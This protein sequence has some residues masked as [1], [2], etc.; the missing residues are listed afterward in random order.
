M[1]IAFPA[2]NHDALRVPPQPCGR[3]MV[4]VRRRKEMQ[5]LSRQLFSDLN[6]RLEPL[7]AA[8]F[9]VS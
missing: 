3:S 2:A 1:H 6:K 7:L 9:L 5:S 8:E 4:D